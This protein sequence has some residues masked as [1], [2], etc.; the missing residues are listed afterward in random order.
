[1]AYYKAIA[2]SSNYYFDVILVELKLLLEELL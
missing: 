1:M 2:N